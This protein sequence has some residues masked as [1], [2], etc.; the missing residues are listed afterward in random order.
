MVLTDHAFSLCLLIFS[1]A[2]A[3]SRAAVPALLQTAVDKYAADAERWAYTQTVISKDRQGKVEEEVVVRNDPSQPY[4]VQWTPL[5]INGQEPTERQVEKYRKEHDK[6]H[7]QRRSLGELLDL[8]KAT[9][10]GGDRNDGH[11]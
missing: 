4:A 8:D 10:V 3:V 11:L 9:V 2:V 5:K 1:C 6:R 7:K